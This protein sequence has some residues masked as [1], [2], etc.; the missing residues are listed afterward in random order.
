MLTSYVFFLSK[1]SIDRRSRVTPT[2]TNIGTHIFFLSFFAKLS[3][4][5]HSRAYIL[6]HI[7]ARTY[8]ISLREYLRQGRSYR[9]VPVGRGPPCRFG[10]KSNI[11][12][13]FGPKPIRLC[14]RSNL[15][16]D[17]KRRPQRKTATCPLVSDSNRS[18]RRTAALQLQQRSAG[19]AAARR[20]D[21][22]VRG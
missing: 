17:S 12:R 19:A 3:T 5:R 2:P 9:V 15:V 13:Y 14:C 6:I 8:I 18:T 21:V 22:G 16:E 7:N 1:L 10:P 11:P 20:P 4:K